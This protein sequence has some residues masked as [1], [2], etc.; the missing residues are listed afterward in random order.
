MGQSMQ[1]CLRNLQDTVVFFDEVRTS[2]KVPGDD[3][4]LDGLN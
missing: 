3:D 1:D 2:V 4:N